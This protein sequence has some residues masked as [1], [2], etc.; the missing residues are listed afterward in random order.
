MRWRIVRYV[1]TVFRLP[2]FE[3]ISSYLNAIDDGAPT[4]REEGWSVVVSVAIRRGQE[5]LRLSIWIFNLGILT[6]VIVQMDLCHGE[7]SI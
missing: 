6:D 1:K 4:T 5:D 2:P 7:R 3:E